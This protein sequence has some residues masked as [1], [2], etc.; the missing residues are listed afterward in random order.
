[1]TKQHTPRFIFYGLIIALFIIAF[2]SL[3]IKQW[4]NS[5]LADAPEATPEVPAP[6]QPASDPVAD[7]VADPSYACQLDINNAND[8]NP[9]TFTFSAINTLGTVGYDWDFG[10]TITASGAIVNHTYTATGNFTIALNCTTDIGGTIALT[11]SVTITSIVTA[12]FSVS[13]GLGGYA[14]FSIMTNNT[15]S[16]GGLTYAWEI[17]DGGGTIASGTDTNI[18]YTFG[19]PGTYT[20][21]LTATDGAGQS[22]VSEATIGVVASPPTADFTLSPT[23]GTAPLNIQVQGV[24]Q[25]GGP[26]TSWSWTFGDGVGTASGIGPHNYT[27]AT[28]GTYLVTLNYVGPGGGGTVSKQVGVFPASEPVNASYTYALAGNTGGGGVRVCFTNTSTGPIVTNQWTFGDGVT[29]TDNGAVV[30]HDY[31]AEGDYVVSLRVVATDP[32]VY[33]TADRT[34]QVTAAPVA[35]FTAS[36]TSIIWGDTVNF[37]STSSTGTIVSWA[38]DFNGD[39][40]TDSTQENPSNIAFSTVGN[41]RVRLT[42]TGP[43]GS[44]YREMIIMV[45]SASLS[46]SFTGSTSLT[47]GASANYD[48]TV[49]NLRGRT[50]TY[51]WTISGPSGLTT[52]STEDIS[53]TFTIA[54]FYFVTFAASTPDGQDCSASRT[55]NVSWPTLGCSI[56]GSLNPAPN[57][58]NTYT[59]SVS[60]LGGR[61]VTYEWYVDGALQG[62]T[63]NALALIWA[64][65]QQGAHTVR[66]VATATNGSGN[67]E[68]TSNLNVAWPTLSCSITGNLSPLPQ[69]P[70]NPT[71]STTYTANISGLAGRSITSYQWTVDGT[72]QAAVGNTLTLSWAWNETGN[73]T[74]AV[75]AVVDNTDSTTVS[76]NPSASVTVSV[77]SLTC[78]MASGDSNP[79]LDETVTFGRNLQNQFGR[80]ITAQSWILQRSDGAGGWIDEATGSGTTLDYQFSLVG[81]TYRVS[82]S[83][84]V[85]EPTNSCTSPWKPVQA[86]G[87]GVDFSCDAWA[88]GNFSPA[89]AGSSYGYTLT[90]D[91]TRRFPLDFVWLL[92]GPSGTRTLGTNSSDVDG[93]VTSPNFSGVDLG[94][95]DNYTLRVEV[96]ST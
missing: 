52:F 32:L 87:V 23:T 93:D 50:P 58:S 90:V 83:V 28:D 49:G 4:N 8:S 35:Q 74:V 96:S 22:Q 19:A 38:W 30:C 57:A 33:S 47:P 68:S 29:I 78:N 20:I 18:S 77:P 94:P 64:V 54:G 51:Q 7:P 85:S 65:G 26:I 62:E 73:Y 80:T 92:V 11:G 5:V 21:R 60:N 72:I 59:A 9:F 91:N 82:Y 13:P 88:G 37:D 15:S 81:A 43:G 2:F 10:D 39:G 48:G 3:P 42:V 56:S 40:T 71:R 84:T 55:V 89:L 69:L 27:Y 79:I 25:G 41:N 95:A 46:C 16:G 6:V 44:S 45:A 53:N 70:D 12:G 1:M 86:A 66:V 61:T 75:T 31:A 63:T 36:S 76:C 67:C 34:I 17:F 14:P 24:D